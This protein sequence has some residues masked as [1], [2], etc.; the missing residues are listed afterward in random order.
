MHS[1]YMGHGQLP[2]YFVCIHQRNQAK[3]LT[4]G[5][6]G[7]GKRGYPQNTVITTAEQKHSQ[8]RK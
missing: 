2:L 1:K 6:V 7:E 5:G 4:G 3:T 8:D